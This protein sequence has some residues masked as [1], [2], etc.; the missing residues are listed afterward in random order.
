MSETI[1]QCNTYHEN[2]L[3]DGNVIAVNRLS[4]EKA[5]KSPNASGF[6]VTKKITINVQNDI[7]LCLNNNCLPVSISRSYLINVIIGFTNC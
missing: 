7:E 3:I 4:I 2:F 1:V 5:L 6:S